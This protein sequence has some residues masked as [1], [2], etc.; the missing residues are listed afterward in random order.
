MFTLYYVDIEELYYFPSC[1]VHSKIVSNSCINFSYQI[2]LCVTIRISYVSTA[3]TI[4]ISCKSMIIYRGQRN[5]YTSWLWWIYIWVSNTRI[6]QQVLCPELIWWFE[7][8]VLFYFLGII[9]V[10]YIFF[11]NI[12]VIDMVK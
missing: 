9:D 6:F 1:K 3:K 5:I 12:Q 2:R 11:W 10:L 7:W 8:R 4:H